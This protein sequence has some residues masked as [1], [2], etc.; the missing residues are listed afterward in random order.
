M[1][2]RETRYMLSRKNKK[3]HDTDRE[4]FFRREGNPGTREFGVKGL[5]G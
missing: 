5:G 1:M 2:A 4:P 3:L